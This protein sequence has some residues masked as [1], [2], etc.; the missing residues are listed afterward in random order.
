MAFCTSCGQQMND[1]AKFCA[2]CGTPIT[3]TASTNNTERKTVFDGEERKCPSCGNPIDNAFAMK[4]T[5][6]GYEFREKKTSGAIDRLIM[7]L[8]NATSEEEKIVIIKNF[9]IPNTREDLFEFMVLSSSNFDEEYHAAHMDKDDIS[10]AWLV[11]VNQC[12][13]KSKLILSNEDD[14]KQISEIYTSIIEKSKRAIQKQKN[15]KKTAAICAIVGAILCAT[16]VLAPIGVIFI[17]CA[18]VKASK[19][20][21]KNKEEK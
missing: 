5:R 2:N 18:V 15:D 10:D 4:C 12:Y 1:G 17:I 13:Q 3:P 9:P 14:R 6:C 20:S 8:E 16:T 11:K 19:F 21:H 7:R